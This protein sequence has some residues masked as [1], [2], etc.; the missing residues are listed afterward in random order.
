M[1]QSRLD[2]INE[3]ARLSKNRELTDAEKKE[4]QT[5]RGEYIAAFHNNLRGQLDQIKIKNPDGT[6]VN[7]KDRKKGDSKLTQ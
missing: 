1:E 7:L 2:R 4:Q 3:L 5:L 6:I